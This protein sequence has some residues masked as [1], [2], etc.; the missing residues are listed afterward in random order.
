MSSLA[1][2]LLSIAGLFS[3]LL[4]L[5]QFL[6]NIRYCVICLAVT[7]TWAVLLALHWL[8]VQ[9]N[10]L[11]TGILMG[12]SSLGVYYLLEKRAPKRLLVFRL[13]LLSSL[14]L[15]VYSL[16]SKAIAVDALFVVALLWAGI[17]MLYAYRT[18]PRIQKKIKALIECCSDW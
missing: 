1:V 13:P 18:R 5:K 11:L 3:L 15:I 9:D 17:G 10:Q 6:K 8:N 7:L 16:L 4:A 12:H 2:V 14:I